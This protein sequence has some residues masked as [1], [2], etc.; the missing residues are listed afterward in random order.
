[1]G[2]A[3]DQPSPYLSQVNFINYELLT[4]EVELPKNE[5]NIDFQDKIPVENS[6]HATEMITIYSII[7]IFVV[8]SVGGVVWWYIRRKK[9]ETHGRLNYC[10]N[11]GCKLDDGSN[12]CQ[13]CGKKIN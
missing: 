12:F 2:G 10:E 3:N 5:K 8:A 9:G 6:G 7:M 4:D 13:E 1:M 11:C